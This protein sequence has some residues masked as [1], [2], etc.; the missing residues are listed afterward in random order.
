MC[1]NL[2]PMPL[3]PS[4]LVYLICALEQSGNKID[5]KVSYNA[6]YRVYTRLITVELASP[7]WSQ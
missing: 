7:Q 2:C 3:I 4:Q 1:A 6:A 5:F